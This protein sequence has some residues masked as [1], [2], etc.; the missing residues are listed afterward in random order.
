MNYVSLNF[1]LADGL[2]RSFIAKYGSIIRWG[3]VMKFLRKMD[4]YREI[5]D[6]TIDDIFDYASDFNLIDG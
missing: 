2:Y 5:N 6:N 4:D 1:R 3:V